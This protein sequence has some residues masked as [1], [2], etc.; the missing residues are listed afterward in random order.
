MK[1][2]LRYISV[3]VISFLSFA[4]CDVHEFPEEG[5]DLVPFLL[6]LD[7]STEMPFYKEI[8]YTRSGDDTKVNVPDHSVRYLVNAYRT[9]N[10]V[11]ENRIPDT[12]FVFV[13]ENIDQL[14]YTA[15]LEL[16]EG[17][18]TFRVWCDYVDVGSTKDKYYNTSDFSEIILMDRN[19]HSG[20]NDFR[21]AFRGTSSATV[22]NPLLYSGDD[23]SAI[24]NQATAQMVRP[25]GK[26]KFVSN[27]VETFIANVTQKMKER[28]QFSADIGTD[29]AFDKIIQSISLGE[30]SVIFRYSAFMP[31]SFNMFTDKPADSWTNMTFRSQLS[32]EE[33]MDVNLGYDYIFVNGTE[34]T[35]SIAVEVYDK[36]G[37]LLSSTN[38]I[39]VPI[40]RSKLTLVK[41]EFLSSIAN[42]GVAI[43][44]GYDGDDYNI[45]IF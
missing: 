31:C 5:K 14:D 25:M 22:L 23:A 6:H 33:G 15:R 36:E 17:D 32:I 8:P 45:E 12:T 26:Y 37:E 30:Y 42:G 16:T 1:K 39:Q 28:G 18:W 24:D 29:Q 44:P 20:S 35:L 43:N 27:D 11:G 3:C 21:D 19:N 34:T 4:G 38:P 41:G 2:I 13:N 7:F 40:V 9:D 10:V